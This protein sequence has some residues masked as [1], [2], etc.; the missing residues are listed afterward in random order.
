MRAE[1]SREHVTW[2]LR[3][4]QDCARLPEAMVFKKVT[5]CLLI[6]SF[7]LPSAMGARNDATFTGSVEVFDIHAHK[8]S[9]VDSAPAVVSWEVTLQDPSQV[10]AELN[11]VFWV[12][13]GITQNYFIV[14]SSTFGGFTNDANQIWTGFERRRPNPQSVNYYVRGFTSDGQV[15]T[16]GGSDGYELVGV[17]PVASESDPPTDVSI[18]DP[19]VATAP[20]N[21]TAGRALTV[22]W[23]QPVD[24]GMGTDLYV[25]SPDVR[26]TSYIVQLST[27]QDF[28][29]GVAATAETNSD[30]E[31]LSVPGLQPGTVYYAR[32][33]PVTK[34]VG[35]TSNSSAG[36]AA[37]EHDECSLVRFSPG[38]TDSKACAKAP[39]DS[40]NCQEARTWGQLF[41]AYERK[42][43]N[44]PFMTGGLGQLMTKDRLEAWVCLRD[45]PCLNE[46]GVNPA[47][48]DLMCFVYDEDDRR[49]IPWDKQSILKLF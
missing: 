43:A 46:A 19:N 44:P 9:W 22:Q 38:D 13:V 45:H 32:V 6:L 36:Q 5:V 8:V 42:G 7:V 28:S 47:P 20:C 41:L 10:D 23:R 30:A 27:T 35:R 11:S 24:R 18:C 16:G 26:I 1:G 34:G 21:N 31:F 39:F 29:S 14:N 25:H 49:F 4:C 15:Y 17:A 48:G 12:K 3:M 40:A 37:R 33:T 2:P